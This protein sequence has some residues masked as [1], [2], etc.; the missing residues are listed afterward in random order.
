M[1]RPGSAGRAPPPAARGRPSASRRLVCVTGRTSPVCGA[2]YCFRFRTRGRISRPAD[3][4][5]SIIEAPPIDRAQA[6]LEL[7]QPAVHP[8]Q[9]LLLSVDARQT[10]NDLL[11]GHARGL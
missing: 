8:L 7:H 3:P 2:I 11:I 4:A 5:A 1:T 6:A 10:A 9:L